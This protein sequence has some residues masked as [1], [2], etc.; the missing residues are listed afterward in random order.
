MATPA[1]EE[2]GDI[3]AADADGGWSENAP[4]LCS[5]LE[6]SKDIF[7]AYPLFSV[8][9]KPTDPQGHNLGDNEYNDGFIVLFC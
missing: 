4:G 2:A 7:I 9:A 1:E 5:C 8:A 6:R 3:E